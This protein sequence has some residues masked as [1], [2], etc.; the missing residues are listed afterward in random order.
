MPSFIYV[1]Y[2]IRCV[3]MRPLRELSERNIESAA[4]V[5]RNAA[6]RRPTRS[7]SMPRL[8]RALELVI[9]L[10]VAKRVYCERAA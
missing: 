3:Q 2:S 9:E 4:S 8:A 10:A 5:Y 1:L 7:Y 6:R